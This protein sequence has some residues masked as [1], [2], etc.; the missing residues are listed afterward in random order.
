MFNFFRVL[1]GA[2]VGKDNFRV[3]LRMNVFENGVFCFAPSSF[4]H[5][6]QHII[7]LFKCIHRLKIFNIKYACDI[8]FA[9][10]FDIFWLQHG[11]FNK[12]DR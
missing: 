9:A 3:N 11:Q 1:A 4:L 5:N 7:L 10:D 6:M 12:K 8:V 2:W